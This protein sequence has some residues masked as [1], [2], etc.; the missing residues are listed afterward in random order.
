LS[1]PEWSTVGDLVEVQR[2][3]RGTL[4]EDYQSPMYARREIRVN[5]MVNLASLSRSQK[6]RMLEVPESGRCEITIDTINHVLDR[7]YAHRQEA[8]HLRFWPLLPLTGSAPIEAWEQ[9]TSEEDRGPTYVLLSAA[10]DRADPSERWLNSVVCPT[11]TAD[12][13]P[14]KTSLLQCWPRPFSFPL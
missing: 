1:L 2:V 13:A 9:D 11:A 7:R 3:A 6:K 5:R 10:D 4:W 8:D 12:R 14:L